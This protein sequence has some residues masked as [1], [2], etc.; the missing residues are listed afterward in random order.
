M[1]L[2]YDRMGIERSLSGNEWLF[3]LFEKLHVTIS[4]VLCY[5]LLKTDILHLKYAFPV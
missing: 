5:L 1:D 2:S 3:S 4:I